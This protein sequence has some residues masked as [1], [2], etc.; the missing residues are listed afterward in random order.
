MGGGYSCKGMGVKME[1][2]GCG[3]TCSVTRLGNKNEIKY[4]KN[5]YAVN[6]KEHQFGL[7]Q[8]N[9]DFPCTGAAGNT[10]TL[11]GVF[12]EHCQ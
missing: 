1:V 12:L 9:I 5:H 8:L 10:L 2:V 4:K 3:W 6:Y 7:N 11:P